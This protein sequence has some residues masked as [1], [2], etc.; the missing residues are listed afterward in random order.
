MANADPFPRSRST[1]PS[2]GGKDAR[3]SAAGTAVDY[4]KMYDRVSSMASIGVWEYDLRQ[5]ELTWTDAV[6]DL[7]ELPRGTRLRRGGSG[8]LQ[9]CFSF[10]DGAVENRSH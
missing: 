1:N 8:L 3:V 4:K 7:F 6:Y 2:K 9:H 10:G 5:H